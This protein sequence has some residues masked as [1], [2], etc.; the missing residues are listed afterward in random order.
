MGSTLSNMVVSVVKAVLVAFT[1]GAAMV[2]LAASLPWLTGTD[3]A[4]AVL[5]ARY[6]Q[7]DPTPETLAAIR[8]DLNLPSSP[9]E[10]MWQWTSGAIR[11]DFGQSWVSGRPVADTVLPAAAVSVEI[12]V[13][14]AVAAVLV[15]VA[16]NIPVLAHAV[17]QVRTG[18]TTARWVA[19]A[20]ASMPQVVL[21]VLGLWVFGVWAK[22]LPVAG[23]DGAEHRV[24]PAL[25]LGVP[26]GGVLA[27]VLA[28]ALQEAAAEGWMVTW[29]AAGVRWWR[30]AGALLQRGVIVMVPLAL[31]IVAGLVG[32]S[33]LVEEVFAISGLGRVTLKAALA[34][35]IPMVQSALGLLVMLGVLLGAFGRVAHQLM[36]GPTV[37]STD[38][39]AAVA[40]AAPPWPWQSRVW[41]VA[42]GLCVAACVTGWFRD[43]SLQPLLRHTSPTLAHPLGTDHMGR[44]VWARLADG[45]MLTVGTGVLM[46]L[47]VLVVGLVLGLLPGTRALVDV[48]N[49]VPEVFMGL[50]LAVVL[51][52]SLVTA[53]V[54]VCLVAWIPLAVHTRTLVAALQSAGFVEAARFGG[55]SRWWIATRHVVP[56]VVPSVARHAVAR[57]PHVTLML[58]S[59]SF[60]GIGAEHDSPEWGKA[61]TDAVPYLTI[62]P[63]AVAAPLGALMIVGLLASPHRAQPGKAPASRKKQRPKQTLG[64]LDHDSDGVT[65]SIS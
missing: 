9:W 52:P 8:A 50:V 53:A 36:R 11:G 27:V 32:A 54:A 16:L 10:G 59:L 51:G 43:T 56:L 42:T 28:G 61:L 60:L 17:W 62:A 34:Q 48:L 46:T 33:V 44:D 63:W 41:M 5:R 29:R 57:L 1:A 15:A 26:C 22:V 47:V 23:W 31:L 39:P 55:A 6:E 49:A 24:L 7:R 19:V 18:R 20:C 13:W 35:D 25:A 37:A 38:E 64:A 12:A 4:L 45:A 2:A 30:I 14:S 65:T 40:D 21:A 3:P 58:A